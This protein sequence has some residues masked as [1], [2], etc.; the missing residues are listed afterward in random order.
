MK[1]I[2]TKFTLLLLVLT[3]LFSCK[4]GEKVL[5][6]I[7]GA[8][9]EILVVSSDKIW[10]SSMG[11]T[12]KNYFSQPLFGLPQE[13]PTFKVL[14]IQPSNFERHLGKHRN[15]I[16]IQVGA[17]ID[18]TQLLYQNGLK[19][20]DQQYFLLQARDS[21][22]LIKLFGQKQSLIENII[23]QAEEKRLTEGY[24]RFPSKKVVALFK[25]KYNIDIKIPEGFNLNNESQNFIWSSLETNKYSQGLIFFQDTLFDATQFNIQISMDRVNEL[26]QEH[27]PGPIDSSWMALDMEFPYIATPTLI[28]DN[29]AVQIRGLWYVENDFMA[30]PYVLNVILDKPGNRVIYAMGYVYYPVEAKRNMVRRLEAIINSIKT[31]PSQKTE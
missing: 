24:T 26:L 27:I 1:Q 11:D 28:H 9:N 25:E 22:E 14:H 18:S 13:E 23:L 12:I 17:N 7:V 4:E 15:V 19:A 30:G 2:S 21:A 5:P 8:P 3:T 6:G 10:N 29:Y 31:I 20:R 16:Q